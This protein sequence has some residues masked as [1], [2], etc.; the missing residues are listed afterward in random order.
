MT[1][2]NT[3]ALFEEIAE[4]RHS[5]RTLLKRATVLG[6]SAPVLAGLLAACGD[7]DEDEDPTAEP[8]VADTDQTAPA[9]GDPTVIDDAGAGDDETPDAEENATPADNGADAEET[10]ED[11]TDSEP[12]GEARRGG[13]LRVATIGEVSTLDMHLTTN[14]NTAFIVWNMY[15][16]LFAWDSEFATLPMLAESFEVSEDGLTNSIKLREGVLFHNGAEMVAADVIASFEHWA[17]FSG[18]GQ[19]IQDVTEEIVE[20]DDYNIEF[21]MNS[22]LG[23]FVVL[24]ARQN[25]GLAIYPASVIEAAGDD[26]I[27]EFIGTG[28]Y[29]FTD[30]QADAY[31]RLSRF[32]DYVGRDEDSNGY[33]GGKAANLDE[34]EFSPVPDEAARIA[35]L[36]AGDYHYLESI[37]PDQ[38]EVLQDDPNVAIEPLP[39]TGWGYLG[40]N[41]VKGPLTDL[42]VR[43]AFLAA[44]DCE[45]IG[46]AAVGE[47]FYRVD[48]GFMLKETIWHSTVSEELYSQGDPEKARQ[49]LDEAGYG[50]TPIRFLASQ[51]YQYQYNAA[52][53]AKQQLEVAGFT[54]E[55]VVSDRA[56]LDA[57]RDI[58]DAWEA[59]SSGYSFRPDPIG[60]PPLDCG[61]SLAWCTDDKNEATA[62][63]QQES[64]FDA[65]YAALKDIQTLWYTQVPGIKLTDN[66]GVVAHSPLLHGLDL[67]LFQLQPEFVNMWLV[68]E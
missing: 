36:Q 7:D 38:I 68:E 37:T 65:R 48:P 52:V 34:L 35:G 59:F 23:T 40:L 3:E 60:M 24:L 51:E 1:E 42:K 62:R 22:P 33:G 19:G 25:Q 47:G 14:T 50:G 58:D 64:D 49:L 16:A 63:L 57:T 43:Q 39:P 18:L 15:E 13:Q 27:T 45:P 11:D 54:V 32:E 17:A 41:S 55:L 46:Q 21:H 12:A 44:I 66:Y 26:Q 9:G 67:T 8:T 4:G 28:P 2:R 5:R 53:V 61:G 29:Q 31:I 30:R 6:L 20:V 56:T 10:P